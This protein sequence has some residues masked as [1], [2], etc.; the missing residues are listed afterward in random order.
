MRVVFLGTP[1]FAVPSLR[2]LLSAGENTH[3]DVRAVITQPDR[4]AGRGLRLTPPP[5]KLI[6]QEGGIP[7]FQPQRLRRAPEIYEMLRQADPELMVVVAFGQ[8]LPADFFQYPRFGTLNIH[9]SLLPKYRGAAPIAHAILNGEAE[10]GT[11]I[12]KIDEGMDT[13]DILSQRSMRIDSEVT[14]GELEVVLAQQG[15][16]L[17]IDT[18]PKYVSGTLSPYSQ[19]NCVA[20]FAPRLQKEQAVIN[21]K[22]TAYVVHNQIR[23]F[24]PWPVASSTLRG[25]ALK[26]WRSSAPQATV[27]AGQAGQIRSIDRLGITVECGTSTSLVLTE[28]QLAARNRNRAFD[29]ANGLQLT[30]GERF[31]G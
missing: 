21:W 6:A 12:M 31:G 15:A 24:N 16:E 22:Q 30:V 3:Y 13:G 14:T 5:V 19:D 27:P 29:L 7:V 20:S 17:L 28:L 8:I 11:T 4:P 2:A 25:Q 9:G 18:I 23:A 26:V 1:E 10:T